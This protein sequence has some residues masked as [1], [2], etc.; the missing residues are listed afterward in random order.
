DIEE[1]NMVIY[2]LYS[3]NGSDITREEFMSDLQ[4]RYYNEEGI[5]RIE[6]A[7]YDIPMYNEDAFIMG[8]YG[9]MES[10]AVETVDV[11]FSSAVDSDSLYTRFGK[12]CTNLVKA[13]EELGIVNDVWH[14]YTYEEYDMLEKANK[15]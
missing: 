12:N 4:M 14:L 10:V 9:A 7:Y 3:I 2:E 1:G 8:G 5:V 6:D 15:M 11:A 13:L